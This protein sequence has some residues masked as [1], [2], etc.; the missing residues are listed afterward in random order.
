[1]DAMGLNLKETAVLGSVAVLND[2]VVFGVWG[3]TTDQMMSVGQV[4]TV[5]SQVGCVD[6]FSLIAAVL[7]CRCSR[8]YTFVDKL[9]C[10]FDRWACCA[11][12]QCSPP[13]SWGH[14]RKN[15]GPVR[16]WPVWNRIQKT[17]SANLGGVFP[18]RSSQDG[19][20]A[21]TGSY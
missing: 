17:Q 2:G 13:M 5:G 18:C 20:W 7:P 8:A 4:P 3:W 11:A 14:E 12:W 10:S 19:R 15:H 16:R 1:M 6:R 9:H 21:K